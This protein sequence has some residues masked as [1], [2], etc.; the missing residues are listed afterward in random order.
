MRN[1]AVVEHVD[2]ISETVL[3]RY[4]SATTKAAVAYVIITDRGL[5][6]HQF[7]VFKRYKLGR[8]IQETRITQNYA[9]ATF[10][11]DPAD[12][13]RAGRTVAERGVVVDSQLFLMSQTPAECWAARGWSKSVARMARLNTVSS[14]EGDQVHDSENGELATNFWDMLRYRRPTTL[15]YS[16]HSCSR[17]EHD[18]QTSRW[19]V[20]P[21]I[22]EDGAASLCL[23][24]KTVGPSSS[25]RPEISCPAWASSGN[26]TP[27]EV[28][29][30]TG[31][32][33]DSV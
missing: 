23:D 12:D 8:I 2:V 13:A 11:L 9:H 7:P 5:P 29:S 3:A 15:F 10:R 31:Q 19:G 16:Q 21:K 30:R 27:A 26:M 1:R 20:V 24:V 4:S 6:F 14:I 32:R 25:L 17:V 28:E 33:G 18:R 22:A